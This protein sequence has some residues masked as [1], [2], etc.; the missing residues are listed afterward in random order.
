MSCLGAESHGFL[1]HAVPFA[2]LV[3]NPGF[4]NIID[5]KDHDD[6]RQYVFMHRDFKGMGRL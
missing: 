3:E 5:G 2:W 6:M 1:I 4:V